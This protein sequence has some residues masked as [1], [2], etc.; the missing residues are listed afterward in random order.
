MGLGAAG[1]VSTGGGRL[2]GIAELV[3]PDRSVSRISC[4]SLQADKPIMPAR[5]TAPSK[6][7]LLCCA[8]SP[9]STLL[10][11]VIPFSTGH[12]FPGRRGCQQNQTGPELGLHHIY[13]G[14]Q[15][16]ASCCLGYT[17]FGLGSVIHESIRLY[18]F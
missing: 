11:F 4:E 15:V 10:M 12:K 5:R 14:D 3:A 16:F 13:P 8:G 2:V 17:N 7:M 6:D 9:N 18:V 1:V